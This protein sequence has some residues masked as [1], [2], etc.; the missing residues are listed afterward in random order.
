[1]TEAQCTEKHL[2]IPFSHEYVISVQLFH[3]NDITI[4]IKPAIAHM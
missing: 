4:D 3:N 1:M 2:F